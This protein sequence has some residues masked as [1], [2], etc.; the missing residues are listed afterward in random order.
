M[1]YGKLVAGLIGL[2]VAGVL[3]L[4]IGLALGHAFDRGLAGVLR[5]GSPEHVARV[6]AAF[7]QTCFQL[8]GYL[9]KADGRV[10][11][12]EVAHTEQ[13]F[14]QMGLTADQRSQAI[15]YFKAGSA[16][17]FDPEPVIASFIEISHGQRQLRQTLL[18][19]L[20][21]M[22]LADHQLEASERAVLER[23]ASLLGYS[24]AQLDQL[25]RMVQA[26]DHFHTGTQGGP[27]ADG[28]LEDAYAAL[29]VSPDVDDR[30]LKR[31]YRKLMS[32]HHPDK[33]IAR[34]VPEDMLKVA[35]ERAQEIQAAYEMIRRSR[36]GR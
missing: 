21:S 16:P 26:Q 27:A 33:L 34:G 19:F 36:G 18:L 35:T 32:E 2:M 28:S 12:T 31:A 3:G 30:Q 8:L 15:R 23:L 5:F 24:A 14:R 13:L 7:F 1:F 29:G 4:L 10:S 25:L 22:A 9:A 17:D 20:V 6:R 11:E